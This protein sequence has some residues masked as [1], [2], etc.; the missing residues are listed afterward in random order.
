MIDVGSGPP[1]VLVPGIQ[2]RW[3]WMLP[4][5]K[6]LSRRHRVLSFSLGEIQEFDDWVARIDDVL[7][8]A[9]EPSA[10]I[11][12]VSFGGVI[13]VH[14]AASRP[15]RT[16]ALVLVSTPAPACRLDDWT[17]WF[18]RHPRL[19]LPLFSARGLVRLVPEILVAR[20]SW[21]QR[22]RLA[23]EYGYRVLRAPISPPQ[24]A[25]YVR[26]WQRVDLSGDC[27]R[28][29]APTLVITGEPHLDRVVQ[30]RTS[31]EYLDRIDGAQYAK[32]SDTGH[33]GLIAKPDLFAAAIDTFLDRGA[34]RRPPAPEREAHAS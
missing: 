29:Q 5:V 32:L 14:Y 9:G 19:A 1:L 24:M 15:A 25:R 7:A 20:R 31:L 30:V 10:V 17:D 2:G 34:V 13:A 26:A 28:V 33:V 8:R 18:V 21:A 6:A 4:A 12:G 27:A 23:V 3:E 11:A 22:L 16:D